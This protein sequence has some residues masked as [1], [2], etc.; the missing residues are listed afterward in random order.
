MVPPLRRGDVD[1]RL[2]RPLHNP[3]M[4]CARVALTPALSPWE[5]GL[6]SRL[7]GNDG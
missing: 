5:M 7:R 6:D 4:E 2:R 3:Q 1:S